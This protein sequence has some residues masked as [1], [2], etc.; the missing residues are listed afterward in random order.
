MCEDNDFRKFWEEYLNY[1]ERD[2]LFIIGRGFDPRMCLCLKE[3][4]SLGGKGKRHCY[5][6]AYDEGKESPSKK[7]KQQVDE[8][9]SQLKKLFSKKEIIIEKEIKLVSDDSKLRIGPREARKA[10]KDFDV[11]KDYSDIIIDISAMPYSIYFPIIEK[12]LSHIEN[13]NKNNCDIKNLHVVVAENERIDNII[14]SVNIQKAKYLPGL[15][16]S[17]NQKSKDYLEKIWIPILG[18]NK[19]TQLNKIYNLINPI[20]VC[21]ILPFPSIN[22]RRGD[23]IFL[24]YADFIFNK[25]GTTDVKRNILYASEKNP[26]DVSRKIIN[27]VIRYT[28]SLKMIGGCICAISALSSKIISLGALLATIDLRKN[29]YVDVGI[30]YTEAQGYNISQDKS[31]EMEKEK[32]ILKSNL[33]S[34]WLAGECYIE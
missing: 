21:F 4:R 15:S 5:L 30:A 12:I 2:L 18:E 13:Y 31:K 26:F 10:F 32:D 14:H 34:I 9:L 23:N 28:K 19:L 33:F 1:K 27:A 24:K 11:M 20:D 3:I 8:N 7:H 6:L 25:L 16:G 29:G 22:P 17:L